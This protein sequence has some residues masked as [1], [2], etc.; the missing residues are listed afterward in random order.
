[1]V[2]VKNFRFG[3]KRRKVERDGCD[4]NPAIRNACI[5]AE[6]FWK[7]K[8]A[9]FPLQETTLFNLFSERR[10]DGLQVTRQWMKSK[11]KFLLRSARPLG[12]E[13]FNDTYKWLDGYMTRFQ[14]VERH[15]T[16]KKQISVEDRLP[17]IRLFHQTAKLFRQPPP[18]N[19]AKYGR[20]A[21]K[22]TFHVDQV[23]LE[24]GKVGKYTLE[25]KGSTFVAV[26]AP[27]RDMSK[28]L[29]TL[30]LTFTAS[31][32]QRV[33]PIIAFRGQPQPLA[34]GFS[35]NFRA[36]SKK[37]QAERQTM[38]KTI[39]VMWQKNAWFDTSMCL[40]YANF[41]SEQ[42]SDG[43]ENFVG[44]DNLS[45]H[46]SSMFKTKMRQ[47]CSALLL[48]TPDGCTDLCAVTDA[49]LGKAVKSRMRKKY[50]THFENHLKFWLDGKNTISDI[51]KLL[52]QWLD[53]SWKDFLAENG[54][55]QILRAFQHCGMLN[56]YDGTE[57][58]LV[59]V[60]GTEN[61]T[62]S[63]SDDSAADSE[64]DKDAQSETDSDSATNEESERE[65]ESDQS[66]EEVEQSPEDE[67]SDSASELDSETEQSKAEQI[68]RELELSWQLSD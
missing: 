16:N 31:A 7:K 67:S 2:A 53:E 64:S 50:E 45:A 58:N 27:K 43:H 28:R 37:L 63:E 56:S 40:S 19:D 6:N 10:E 57:D 65:S 32:P 44:M 36:K 61:Y 46:C 68:N 3:E 51:R 1:L 52:A 20:F 23:P 38:P 8:S 33:Q 22:N 24:F 5:H 18:L 49:G 15:R 55:N 12:W 66:S 14:I 4:P 26:K 13:K 35:N 9:K 21:A 59:K 60:T 30:Q 34:N 54:E 29:A 47:D 11:M 17:Q 41:F 25:M 39:G 48:Y 62:F 42:I